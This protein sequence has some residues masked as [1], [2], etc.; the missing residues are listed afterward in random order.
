[1]LE[2]S[3]WSK[4]SRRTDDDVVFKHLQRASE[5]VEIDEDD[6]AWRD[7]L[8]RSTDVEKQDPI[9][10]MPDQPEPGYIPINAILLI[11]EAGEDFRPSLG[12]E[13]NIWPQNGEGIYVA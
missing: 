11:G 13:G 3:T 2:K 12:A 10:P 7:L 4:G 5:E 8:R 1:M 9:S 6:G